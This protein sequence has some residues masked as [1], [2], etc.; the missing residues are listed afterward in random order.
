MRR[1]SRLPEWVLKHRRKGTEIKRVGGGY[2]LC[3]VKSVWNPEKGRPR[4]ISG[5]YLGKITREGLVKPRHERVLESLRDVTVKEFGAAHLLQSMNEDMVGLLKELYPNE[6]KE[7]FVFAAFRLKNNSPLK[8]V[9]HHYNDSYLSETIDGAMVSPKVLGK[10][11]RDIGSQRGKI[12]QFLKEF[13]AGVN[14]AVIDLTHV[15]SLSENVISSTLGHNSEGEYLPQV[16]FTIL[17][18]LDRRQPAYFRIM[19]GS[20]RDVSSVV[21]T[22]KEAGIKGAVLLGDKGFYSSDNVK[23]LKGEKIKYVLPLKRNST[24]IDYGPVKSG[25]RKNFDGYFFFEG[26]HIWYCS[27]ELSG[28]DRVI[29]FSDEKLKVEEE[30]DFLSRVEAKKRTLKEFYENQ[31]RLGTLSVIT[32]YRRKPKRIFELLKSRVEVEK[33]F[34]T[35]KNTLNADRSY[36]R[37]DYQMEGWMFVNFIAMLFY[38]RIYGLLLEREML[39]NYSPSDILLHLSRVRKIRIGENWRFA[40]IPKQSRNIIEKLGIDIPI[41][42]NRR[43]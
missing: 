30:K 3:E 35:F 9:I 14:F 27:T 32:D 34:D 43:S 16:N 18:S 11:L 5:K 4:K 13:V 29:T 23:T 26:R 41:P 28:D 31:F 2:Y 40:E 39:N 33:L 15:F 20:I 25:D 19:P 37:D 6:W 24:L 10:L 7:L 12:T 22:V 21:L 38:Y 1:K 17:Y 8:N 36:M 42:K